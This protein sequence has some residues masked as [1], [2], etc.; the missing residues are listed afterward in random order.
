MAL[1]SE[2][3]SESIS[4]AARVPAAQPL[5]L[6]TRWSIV[7][8][9]DSSN[10]ASAANALETL[11]SS[12]WPAVY[13]F[14]LRFGNDPETARDLTQAFFLDLLQSR[15]YLR[16]SP[17]RGRFRSFLLG[18]LKHFLADEHDRSRAQ[19][20][21]G[22]LAFLRFDTL[23]ADSSPSALLPPDH[24]FDRDWAL[25]TLDRSLARLR[26][27]FQLSGRAALF[28]SLKQFL[29]GEKTA[30]YAEVAAE[31]R[32]TEGAAKMTV[33]RMRHRFR[34]IVRQ[35]IAETVTTPDQ[36]ETEL[37]SFLH[38]LTT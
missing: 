7:A 32:I 6:T 9:A 14:I 29:S 4:E 18:T 2:S 28:D 26:E 12:Y 17:D 23:M 38:A 37:Q 21:G 31:L 8:A 36:L 1:S 24:Q 11:C 34:A 30:S 35:E 16:A 19:K 33:T 10:P 20:R 25:A 27:E 15:A 5:F 22:H 13:R 3:S